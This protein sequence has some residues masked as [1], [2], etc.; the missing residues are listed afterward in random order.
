M[1]AVGVVSTIPPRLQQHC[2]TQSLAKICMKT[3]IGESIKEE[4]RERQA[5][6]Q[7]KNAFLSSRTSNQSENTTQLL[8]I[9]EQRNLSIMSES[10]LIRSNRQEY[11][12]V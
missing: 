8:Q 12:Q 4:I 3:S 1:I 10:R 11:D 6:Q 7:S 9:L 5:R 2:R